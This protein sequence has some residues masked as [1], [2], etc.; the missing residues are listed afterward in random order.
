MPDRLS[1]RDR[2]ILEKEFPPNGPCMF[3]PTLYARHRVID[4]I[5]NEHRYTRS[6]K[7]LTENFMRDSV[8]AVRI[9]VRATDAQ[10][11]FLRR[12][13]RPTCRTCWP[14]HDAA[15]KC[16]PQKRAKEGR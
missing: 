7:K 2:S 16:D 1:A 5:R 14:F 13:R 4:S 11:A 9:L 15:K 10:I 6:A 12:Y 3:H 8:V